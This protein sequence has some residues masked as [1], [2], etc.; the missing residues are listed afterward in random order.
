MKLSLL[1]VCILFIQSCF[2]QEPKNGIDSDAFRIPKKDI[3]F[4]G[5]QTPPSKLVQSSKHFITTQCGHNSVLVYQSHADNLYL[6]I[7]KKGHYRKSDLK[8]PLQLSRLYTNISY[9][10][11]FDSL[12]T[13]Q[14][15]LVI[16]WF[17]NQHTHHSIY[18]GSND[19]LCNQTT[20]EN[21]NNDYGVTIISLTTQE[22]LFQGVLE[23]KM[24]VY[25]TTYPLETIKTGQQPSYKKQNIGL[26]HLI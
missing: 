11:E 4:L 25:V 20:H 19:L 15:Y 10:F 16:K 21:V 5:T 6:I 24:K 7:G 12:G 22:I 18:S 14:P 23:Y 17:A 9:T 13:T 3:R 26:N 8:L 2:S 1:F